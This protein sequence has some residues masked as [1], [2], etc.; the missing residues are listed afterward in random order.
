LP[1][2]VREVLVFEEKLEQSDAAEEH[3]AGA[4]ALPGSTALY[5]RDMLPPPF[6]VFFPTRPGEELRDRAPT[7]L[8]KVL[9]KRH[10][11]RMVHRSLSLR[12][13]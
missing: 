7:R 11:G 1:V 6:A 9:K 2:F 8:S 13:C 3:A 5:P 10:C 12:T 4:A